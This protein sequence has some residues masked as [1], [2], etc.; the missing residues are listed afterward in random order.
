MSRALTI[1]EALHLDAIGCFFDQAIYSKACEI[2]WREPE[3]LKCCMLM[4]RIFHLP[5]W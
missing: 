4:M 3:K 5:I 1:V 2:K